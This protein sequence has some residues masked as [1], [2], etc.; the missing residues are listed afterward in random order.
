MHIDEHGRRA[1]QHHR[2]EVELRAIA[3][4]RDQRLVHRSPCKWKAVIEVND[5]RAE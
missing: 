4:V 5:I 1:D 2:L 3:E